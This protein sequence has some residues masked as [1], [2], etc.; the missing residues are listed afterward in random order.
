MY[1]FIH[2]VDRNRNEGFFVSNRNLTSEADFAFSSQNYK[3]GLISIDEFRQEIS[4]YKGGQFKAK[5]G[6]M[7]LN[8][9]IFDN[10]PYFPKIL[11][12]QIFFGKSLMVGY[13]KLLFSGLIQLKDINSD[14]PEITYE[15]V[16][17]APQ[18]DTSTLTVGSVTAT[19]E[20][21]D[22]LYTMQIDNNEKSILPHVFGAVRNE[23][24]VRIQDEN[25]N[26]TYYRAFIGG[27]FGYPG[28]E[29]VSMASAAAG[30]KT[31]VTVADSTFLFVG[32]FVYFETDVDGV[33]DPVE[34]GGNGYEIEV[35][36]G[37]VLTV[38]IP[39][40]AT[41][42]GC[43]YTETQW[44][45]YD[46]AGTCILG[47]IVNYSTCASLPYV[48]L[49][50]EPIAP[51]TISGMSLLT[52]YTRIEVVLNIYFNFIDNCNFPISPLI[53]TGITY[54]EIGHYATENKSVFDFM[55]DVFKSKGLVFGVRRLSMIE[56]DDQ[57]IPF[58]EYGNETGSK[59]Y[60][61]WHEIMTPEFDGFDTDFILTLDSNQFLYKP[62]YINPK[63]VHNL[64]TTCIKKYPIEI[65]GER[66]IKNDPFVFETDLGP[67]SGT[68]DEI[69]SFN[70]EFLTETQWNG[71]GGIGSQ[72]LYLENHRKI[73]IVVPLDLL[74]EIWCED[75]TY[76]GETVSIMKDL[77]PRMI[78]VFE[79]QGETIRM[80]LRGVQ[81]NYNENEV[82]LFGDELNNGPEVYV[83][84]PE[85]LWNVGVS[86]SLSI[87]KSNYIDPDQDILVF[88]TY[89]SAPWMGIDYD[90]MADLGHPTIDL[91]P[92][93]TATEIGVSYFEFYVVDPSDIYF[94]NLILEKIMLSVA[95]PDMVAHYIFEDN[96]IYWDSE[97]KRFIDQ[98]GNGNH[99]YWQGTFDPDF[100]DYIATD[101]AI[102][103][104]DSANNYLIVPHS[105]S[106]NLTS[107]IRVDFISNKNFYLSKQDSW[108]S[109]DGYGIKLIDDGLGLGGPQET[110]M[111][112]FADP[113]YLSLGSVDVGW[114]LKS[115][116][117]E[118]IGDYALYIEGVIDNNAPVPAGYSLS[119]NTNDLLIGKMPSETM[120]SH[121]LAELKI[122]NTIS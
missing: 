80:F 76:D 74:S 28:A 108:N 113:D 2:I 104:G 117:Y 15:L 78:V 35:K 61:V 90:G 115:W 45:L 89:S 86:E 13:S 49:N 10:Y 34:D 97:N 105:T 101:D 4:D 109:E 112:G 72:L 32:D 64:K 53:S 63:Y 118:E 66:L 100:T 79:D 70:N 111:Y 81:I 107:E 17:E 40:V 99:A 20:K 1:I 8:K 96:P 19:R 56:K 68:V 110:Y 84:T 93:I 5:F 25:S 54:P 55:D 16:E 52:I 6:N 122:F 77:Y 120:V 41:G 59:E 57:S 22:L 48:E 21:T 24:P 62:E 102:R 3:D 94:E 121:E 18:L 9:N 114:K 103:M 106:L 31:D 11:D 71:L 67:F 30:A 83:E 7:I 91:T 51:V 69:P 92:T 42:T 88:F 85:Q 36:A 26:P 23:I 95:D 37:N 29:I 47:N 82:K 75:V 65:E 44:R 73:K 33:Y 119:T 87:P 12:T 14:G 46:N 98:S 116:R 38:D 60:V 27:P 58:D 43:I 50:A 39:F